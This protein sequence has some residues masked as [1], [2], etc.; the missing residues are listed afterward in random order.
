MEQYV[1]HPATTMLVPVAAVLLQ[2]LLPKWFPR[3]GGLFDLPLIVTIFFAVARRNPIYGTLTGTGIGLFQDALT[4]LPLGINGMAKAL[5]GYM[6]A[7]IGVRL[8]VENGL[9]RAMLAFGFSLMQSV[10]LFL[11]RSRLLGTT[12]LQVLWLHEILSAIANTAIAI[13]VFLMLDR[14]KRQE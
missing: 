1:F 2:A 4:N 8:D 6:A 13:P 11:I 7:S 12:G 5:V 10:L 9:T 14:T 3:V